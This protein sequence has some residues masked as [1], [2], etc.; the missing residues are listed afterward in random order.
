MNKHETATERHE[1]TRFEHFLL[2]ER[3][4]TEA[5]QSLRKKAKQISRLMPSVNC[6]SLV[7]LFHNKRGEY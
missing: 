3:I 6:Q 2:S 4:K 1:I 7:P 5:G